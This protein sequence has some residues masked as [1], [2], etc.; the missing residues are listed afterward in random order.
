[1]SRC[2]R[3]P[4][5]TIS[6][7]K[8]KFDVAIF[9]GQHTRTGEPHHWADQ[10]V[11][12]QFAREELGA[13]PFDHCDAR[14]IP[15]EVEDARKESFSRICAA[16]EP[17][18]TS[19]HRVFVFML[20]VCGRRF[21]LLRWD[22]AGL[23]TT[24]SVDYYE[25]HALLCDFFWRVAHLDDTALGF[26][27]SATR[28]LP[29]DPD[30]LR[31]DLA[32]RHDPSDIDHTERDL[33]WGELEEPFVFDYVRSL[34]RE[35]IATSWPRFRLQVSHGD[36]ARE[37][38]VGKPV[39]MAEGVSGR[40]TR[41]YIA[42]DCHTRGF[43]WL[44]DTWR[45]SYAN[46]E[47]EGDIL[48]R[49]NAAGIDGVPTLV[50]HGDVRNQVT[51]TGDWWERT[52]P[53]PF[54]TSPSSSKTNTSTSR[55]S[56]RP[57]S[58]DNRK[59][60]WR[61][62]VDDDV[63]ESVLSEPSHRAAALS[64]CP[65]RQHTH[66]RIVV[67]EICLPLTEFKNGKQLVK[68]MLDCLR[69]H[70]QAATH[71]GVRLLHCDVS[72][73]NILIY[74]RLRK[75]TN[76]LALVWSGVLSDW[77]LSRRIDEQMPPQA[78][79]KDRIGTY[80]FMSVNLLQRPSE[81]PKIAD[82]LE[83]FL[84]VM[85]YNAVR[86]L[87][88]NCNDP[89]WWVTT[90]FD[91]YAGPGHMHTCGQKSVAIE[92]SG[93]LKTLSPRGPLVFYSPMDGLCFTALQSFRARYKVMEYEPQAGALPCPSPPRSPPRS[94][95]SPPASGHTHVYDQARSIGIDEKIIAQIE[96]EW[97]TWTPPDDSPT[98]EDR[99]LAENLVDHQFM[100]ELFEKV[101]GNPRW[102][103]HDRITQ[104]RPL[105]RET[106]MSTT[107]A[108][109]AVAEDH[110]SST[111]AKIPRNKRRRTTKTQKNASRP[112]RLQETTRRT[113]SQTRKEALTHPVHAK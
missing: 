91:H 87:R 109:A 79:L 9:T 7:I 11:P 17:L 105:S 100:I 52:H 33:H 15:E 57:L 27:P 13:D 18:F 99:R 93:R 86:H 10:V 36:M 64:R 82:E 83:S 5:E 48:S 106:K 46:F 34:F 32:A 59:R 103:E 3:N 47:K 92:T 1:M 80:Q 53:L 70:Q 111:P 12:V 24:P 110:K 89:A 35:S 96:A 16:V 63:S 6:K 56:P 58:L 94:S 2:S 25:N 61:D 108:V 50:C 67:K 75:T 29:G 84:H 85:V 4:C 8:S 31:M 77:E 54:S 60:K 43:V 49:L 107:A 113:R 112:P 78:T 66:Y 102:P 22:H 14:D 72:S 88:S 68:V 20:F 97:D 98:V 42:L 62:V 90:Y 30:Y 44:K 37:F 74:P 101:L 76:G 38:L 19:Q 69:T 104:P 26:D 81:T 71:P 73:G 40:G 65:L 21:R 39:F 23:V 28:V 51:V 55:P 95:R 45:L 41:G